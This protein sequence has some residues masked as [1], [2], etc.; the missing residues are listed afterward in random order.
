M[1]GAWVLAGIYYLCF[2]CCFKQLKVSIA[3][4][5]T[6]CDWF[7]DTKRI[8]FVPVGYFLLGAVVFCTWFYAILNVAS[9]SEDGI[10]ASNPST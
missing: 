5:E 2:C 6:A 3:I 1:I 10:K 4:I 7:A 8:V 9:I